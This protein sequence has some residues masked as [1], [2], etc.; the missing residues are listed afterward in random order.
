M[1]RTTIQFWNRFNTLPNSIQR[2]AR[3]NFELLKKNQAHPSL[4]FK[5][6]GD[7]W[8][9]R[10]SQSYS[11]NNEKYPS[12]NIMLDIEQFIEELSLK[13][14]AIIFSPNNLF[15]VTDISIQFI[16]F[17]SPYRGEHRVVVAAV[18][19]QFLPVRRGGK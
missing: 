12:V 10:I 7:Y 19:D 9:V 14:I 13:A 17:L 6:V 5:K 4:Q 3:K 16:S 1:H 18:A 11:S 15:V 2:T 8:S